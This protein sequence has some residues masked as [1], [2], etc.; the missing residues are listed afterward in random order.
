MLLSLVGVVVLLQLA[1]DRLGE[2]HNIF[3]LFQEICVADGG[4]LLPKLAILLLN[5]GARR[6]ILMI[7]ELL[8]PKYPWSYCLV[9]ITKGSLMFSLPSVWSCLLLMIAGCVNRIITSFKFICLARERSS[10][11]LVSLLDS[12]SYCCISLDKI[13]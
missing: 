11:I 6:L 8:V 5:I 12:C 3:A 7:G 4:G 2:L 9:S 1:L 10:L 13:E